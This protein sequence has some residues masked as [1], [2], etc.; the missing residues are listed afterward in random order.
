MCKGAVDLTQQVRWSIRCPGW[1]MRTKLNLAIVFVLLFFGLTTLEFPELLTLTDNTS[2]D[3]A[4]I[5]STQNASRNAKSE[6]P[7]P[8]P[9]TIRLR[10]SDE[11][12]G[13]GNRFELR[14]V[15]HSLH[16]SSDYI[17][18]LRVYRT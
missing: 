16:S 10:L 8:A 1:P 15:Q 14:D 3:F 18:F 12:L 4:L 6:K 5:A 17:D 2:N 13:A 7:R 11:F 9:K